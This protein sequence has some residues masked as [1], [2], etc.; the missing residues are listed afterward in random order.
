MHGNNNYDGLKY[1]AIAVIV[2]LLLAWFQT[3]SGRRQRIMELEEQVE[4]YEEQITEYEYIIE[5]LEQKNDSLSEAL[6]Q[7]EDD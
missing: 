3:D 6:I 4:Q 5:D 2:F 7:Y 1:I